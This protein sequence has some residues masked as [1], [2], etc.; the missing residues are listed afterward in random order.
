M[1]LE[2]ATARIRVAMTAAPAE[3][4]A[5]R[6]PVALPPPAPEPLPYVTCA[7]PTN[8]RRRF[9][10]SA[11]AGFFAQTYPACELIINDDGADSIADL[12]P[13][14]PRI[15][16]MRHA[17]R[18]S[19]GAKRNQCAELAGGT[20]IV[21]WDDDDWQAPW[22]VAYQVGLLEQSGAHYCGTRRIL[23]YEPATDRAWL[24]G[25]PLLMPAFFF[26]C[27]IAY[28]R[29]LWERHP[30][31]PVTGDEDVRFARAIRREAGVLA[32][33]P[34]LVAMIHA[35]NVSPKAR[36]GAY[37]HAQP[38]TMVHNLLGADVRAYR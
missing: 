12:I 30:F 22:R 9:I 11:L 5:R 19:L 8:N 17:D 34:Y 37:W 29:A 3:Q 27:C 31:E 24:F 16:Y 35:V 1:A 13:D 21:H 10:P 28:R 36:R 23:H 25:V 14:D 32:L 33:K 15:R 20:I 38:A 4:Q 18:H 26:G 2:T 7:M 6:A